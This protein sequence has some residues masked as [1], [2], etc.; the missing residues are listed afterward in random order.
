MQPA[1]S[2]RLKRRREQKE[3]KLKCFQHLEV[4]TGADDPKANGRNRRKTPDERKNP[5]V[6]QKEV[7]LRKQG[8][9]K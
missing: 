6:K 2:Y 7:Q 1:E 5:V 4:T 8:V 3:K 9:V